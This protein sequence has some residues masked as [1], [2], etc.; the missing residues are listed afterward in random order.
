M[1]REGEPRRVNS[2]ATQGE[3][4]PRRL[5]RKP[6]EAGVA[7]SGSEFTRPSPRAANLHAATLCARARERSDAGPPPQVEPIYQST[8][9]KLGSLEECDAI[10]EGARPGHIY[11]RDSNPNHQTLESLVAQLEGAEAALVTASG[12]GAIAV[13]LLATVQSGDSIVASDCL[14]GASTRLMAEEFARFGVRATLA[15]LHDEQAARERIRAPVRAVFVETIT[16]PLLRVV[17]LPLLADLCREAGA[18][19][20]VDNTFATPCLIRPLEHGADAVVHS[21][22]KFIGGHSDVM[23]GAVAGSEKFIAAAR[24]R[25]LTWGI[26]AN[27]F[28]AWLALRGA[29]TLPLRIERAGANAARLAAFLSAHPRVRKTIYPGLPSHPDHESARRLLVGGGAML[30]FELAGETEVD[31]LIRL[32]QLVTFSPSLGDVATTLSYPAK[33]S[34]RKLSAEQRAALGITPGLV[35]VSVGIDDAEDVIADFSLAL[36]G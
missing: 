31:R 24:A 11:I 35:R 32:L 2:R 9:W 17:D 25:A 5:D 23:L 12:M 28:G 22:T 10:Y 33:T 26:P 18:A 21:L 3:A 30:A 20:V 36:E 6:A 1:E 15:P 16:N 8:V 14:Y 4:D 29:A 13:A 7:R 27:P 19:L 34:H